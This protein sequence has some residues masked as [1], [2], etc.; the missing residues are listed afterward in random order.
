MSQKNQR[1]GI[2]DERDR[3]YQWAAFNPGIFIE[4]HTICGGKTGSCVQNNGTKQY[5]V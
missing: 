5:S 4:I 2:F 1:G 3:N